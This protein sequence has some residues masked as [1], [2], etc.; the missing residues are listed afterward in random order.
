VT[1]RTHRIDCPFPPCDAWWNV[2][3][4][5]T[6]VPYHNLRGMDI[7]PIFHKFR[8]PGSLTNFYLG[9]NN[10]LQ[11]DVERM[12]RGLAL[13]EQRVEE[14]RTAE[15][16]R[17]EQ[18]RAAEGEAVDETPRLIQEGKEP[19]LSEGT[20]VYFPGRPADAPEPG[21]NDEPAQVLPMG[22]GYKA[23][24][25]EMSDAH[26]TTRELT[27]LARNKMQETI[28]K[29]QACAA[30]LNGAVGLAT[31]AE[32]EMTAASALSIAAVGSGHGKP[33]P[34]ERMAEQTALAVST[35]MGTEGGNIFN[36]IEV[37]RIRVETAAQQLA[38]AVDNANQ[39]IALLS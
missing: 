33:Q 20:V 38:S 24:K 2:S 3:A 9:T 26:E 37:S 11:A 31:M 39:Y 27:V 15:A 6:Q 17:V 12:R 25:A 21:P 32:A 16:Y 7:P 13:Y 36:A 30:A 8:C 18:L 22:S 1:T 14:W 28:S 10:P 5:V 23:G 29:L 4:N 34:A 35:I 19:D